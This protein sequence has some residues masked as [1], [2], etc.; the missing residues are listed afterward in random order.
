MKRLPLAILI[1]SL[2]VLGT[3]A[4][5]YQWV[6]E[7]GAENGDPV[8]VAIRPGSSGGVI[9]QSLERKGVIRSALSFRIYM[10]LSGINRELRA[11]EYGLRTRMGYDDLLTK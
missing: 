6:F 11:G 8:T 4:A 7:K 10:K 2:L 9:A 1:T 5:T 3:A